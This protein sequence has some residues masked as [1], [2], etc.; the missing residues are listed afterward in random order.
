MG[1]VGAEGST[2]VPLP[3]SVS[4]QLLLPSQLWWCSCGSF[5]MIRRHVV[6]APHSWCRGSKVQLCLPRWDGVSWRLLSPSCTSRWLVVLKRFMFDFWG[7]SGGNHDGCCPNISGSRLS[8]SRVVVA[9][10][11]TVQ[12]CPW[13][14]WFVSLRLPLCRY[15]ACSSQRTTSTA[16]SGT[17]I[18]QNNLLL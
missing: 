9:V 2:S 6:W 11:Q 3:T 12:W 13:G 16:H 1:P 8:C 14:R 10:L 4:G 5:S 17:L 15:P 18:Q 7:S